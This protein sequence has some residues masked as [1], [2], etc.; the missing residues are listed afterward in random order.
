MEIAVQ[1]NN[2]QMKGLQLSDTIF[3]SPDFT[4][5]IVSHFLRKLY[6][7]MLEEEFPECLKPLIEKL[8][9]QEQANR[10]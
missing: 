10:H 8:E 6:T 4:A 9:A 2:E 1:V 7:D 3:P 5:K